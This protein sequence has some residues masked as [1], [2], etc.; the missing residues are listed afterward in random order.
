M[1]NTKAVRIRMDLINPVVYLGSDNFLLSKTHGAVPP[2][3][4]KDAMY[5]L[6]AT[7]LWW[8]IVIMRF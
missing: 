4:G 8:Q 2:C 1:F 5:Q 7:S 3:E 6:T